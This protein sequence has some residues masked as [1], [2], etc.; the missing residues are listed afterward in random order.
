VVFK[1][2]R[3]QKEYQHN[4][5]LRKKAGLETK[6]KPV[7]TPKEKYERTQRLKK[8]Q[9]RLIRQRKRDIIGKKIG[10]DCFFCGC[11]IRLQAHRK[12]GKKHSSLPNLPKRNLISELE[13]NSD[14]YVRLCYKCHKS[15]HWCMKFM[16]LSWEQI[17]PKKRQS[18]N[19]KASSSILDSS[20]TLLY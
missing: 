14:K 19:E 2:K 13:Q 3:V 1:D 10:S 18:R 6:T 17:T 4:W 16:G 15:V 9:N 7:L 12:D 8:I 11:V 20:I 5:Y